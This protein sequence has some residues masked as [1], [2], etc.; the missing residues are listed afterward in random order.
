M[1][2]TGG[3]RQHEAGHTEQSDSQAAMRAKV[4]PAR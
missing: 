2:T 4:A 1:R 3:M